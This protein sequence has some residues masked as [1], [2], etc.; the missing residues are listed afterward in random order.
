MCVYIYD[1]IFILHIFLGTLETIGNCSNSLKSWLGSKLMINISFV[2]K[3]GF[4]T[5]SIK[6]LLMSFGG[7]LLTFY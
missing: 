7:F 4:Y 2:C 5:A 3:N 1:Y 6:I